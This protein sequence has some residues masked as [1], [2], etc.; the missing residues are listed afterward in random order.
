MLAFGSSCYG[1]TF[2]CQSIF[3]C[4]NKLCQ[5]SN[6]TFYQ[7]GKCLPKLGPNE[8]CLS[9]S[10][11][12]LCPNC[13]TCSQCQDYLSYSCDS[14]T[15]KCIC[16]S[17][18]YY[19]DSVSSQCQLKKSYNLTCTSNDTC[20]SLSQSLYCQTTQSGSSCPY[21]PLSGYCNCPFGTYWNGN[22]CRSTETYYG[23]CIGNCSCDTTKLLLCDMLSDPRC[24][25]PTNYYWDTITSFCLPQLT[26]NSTCTLSSQCLVTK[27]IKIIEI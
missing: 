8:N 13:T 23:S 15:L 6:T 22:N 10:Y 11:S 25:C 16:S 9:C 3:T 26:Y 21:M 12:S 17:N 2:Q 19:F 18:A 27:G 1:G 14:L 5:C 7:N 24:M 20:N 4:I